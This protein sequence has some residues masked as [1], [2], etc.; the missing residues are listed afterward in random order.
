MV[1]FITFFVPQFAGKQLILRED[2]WKSLV[3]RESG[4]DRKG[5]SG[6]SS[7]AYP[8]LALVSCWEESKI[9]LN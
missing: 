8:L 1:V 9:V 3:V 7:K 6:V 2:D 5:F 4:E